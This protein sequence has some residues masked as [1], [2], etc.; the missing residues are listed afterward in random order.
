MKALRAVLLQTIQYKTKDRTKK[1]QSIIAQIRGPHI[2]KDDS[3]RLV[4][5]QQPLGIPSLPPT[6]RDDVIC[7][8]YQIKLSVGVSFGEDLGLVLPVVMGT[9]PHMEEKPVE[10][11]G[12][13]EQAEPEPVSYVVPGPVVDVDGVF[14]YPEMGIPVYSR[15]VQVTRVGGK[16][17]KGESNVSFIDEED[18]QARYKPVY[19]FAQ[20]GKPGKSAIA[21]MDKTVGSGS[22]AVVKEDKDGKLKSMME[23]MEEEDEEKEE[24][25]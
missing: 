21:S 15:P 11:Y 24:E 10:K 16:K 4:W 6:I 13:P 5:E 14:G 20:P 7:V 22:K 8:D 1:I 9:V 18:G 17:G 25:E 19:T 3:P 2:K 12:T 23:V